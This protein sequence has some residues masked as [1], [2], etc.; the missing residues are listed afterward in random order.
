MSQSER[1]ID[2]SNWS[3]IALWLVFGLYFISLLVSFSFEYTDIDQVLMWYGAH[4]FREFDFHMPRFFGQN[5]GSMLEAL[6][7][8][9]LFFLPDHIALPLATT[10]LMLLPYILILRHF[11]FERKALIAVAFLLAVM[12]M[13]YLMIATM[14]R[15]FMTGLAITS[16]AIPFLRNERWWARM[17]IGLFCILGWSANNNS[18]LFG[19]VISV[20]AVV[21]QSGIDWRST[22]KIGLGYA[23]GFG[24]HLL[25]SSFGKN[26]PE[27]IVHIAWAFHYHWKQVW[28]G[29]TNFDRHFRWLTPVLHG[30]GWFVMLLFP[31]L[32]GWFFY[33]GKRA[34]AWSGV[35]L[36][37]LILA[38]FGILKVHDG[39]DS[40]FLAH[41]R[42]FL[43]LPVCM[44]FFLSGISWSG[45]YVYVALAAIGIGFCGYNLV[46]MD[47]RIAD[48]VSPDRK[49][50]R[51][52]L[53]ITHEQVEDDCARLKELVD[54]YQAEA[55]IIYPNGYYTGL[56]SYACPCSD[57]ETIY[58]DPEY[59]RKTW[60]MRALDQ[61]AYRSVIVINPRSPLEMQAPHGI[62]VTAL[63]M[64][65]AYLIQSNDPFN[66]L[67]VMRDFGYV[68]STH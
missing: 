43:A 18:A 42:M 59:E 7:A 33:R 50:N 68:I 56:H 67:Q 14:P 35:A 64:R 2:L 28:D 47:Q 13:E 36:V 1:H 65:D 19:A 40:V 39:Y 34:Q 66:P 45:R 31:A 29:W 5:Y 53:H 52:F 27:Y 46:S 23:L 9:P 58:V 21:R 25:I 57:R 11:K 10:V 16:L 44:A 48:H 30:Q 4:E 8:V 24:A 17:L 63:E 6:V 32:V 41:E 55:V 37:V 38:V 26:H 3:T 15:D 61:E 12:P 51:G 22:W 60:D 54:Q 62:V 49:D 20:Y